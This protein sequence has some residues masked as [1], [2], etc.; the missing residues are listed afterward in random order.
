MTKVE[1]CPDCVKN[2]I[3][4]KRSGI[5]KGLSLTCMTGGAEVCKVIQ[6]CGNKVTDVGDKG[7]KT[8]F[9][10]YQRICSLSIAVIS[11]RI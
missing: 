5:P 9:S 1:V 10:K 7:I 11:A 6:I 8:E 2:G 4:S 3:R